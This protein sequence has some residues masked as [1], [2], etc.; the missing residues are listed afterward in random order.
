MSTIIINCNIYQGVSEMI[1][2]HYFSKSL[3]GC[4]STRYSILYIFK[5][6]LKIRM[7][8]F[9]AKSDHTININSNL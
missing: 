2:I 9:T 1:F 4:I 5:V 8:P 7:E 3:N 6:T